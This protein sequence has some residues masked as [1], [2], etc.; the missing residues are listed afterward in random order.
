[1]GQV[2]FV[3]HNINSFKHRIHLHFPGLA[4]IALDTQTWLEV[5]IYMR[6]EKLDRLQQGYSYGC[7]SEDINLASLSETG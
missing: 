7:K 6:C 4:S 2:V 5:L 3:I 1:M